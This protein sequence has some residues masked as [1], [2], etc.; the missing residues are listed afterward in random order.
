MFDVW[1]NLDLM[2]KNLALKNKLS[3][4]RRLFETNIDNLNIKV[5]VGYNNSLKSQKHIHEN[6]FFIANN[7]EYYENRGSTE[8]E[9][10]D[11][12]KYLQE[13]DKFDEFKWRLEE[14]LIVDI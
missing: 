11:F 9:F 7:D 13:E 12:V 8:Y 5:I 2:H 14:K 3:S 6:R 1:K 10:V 4:G